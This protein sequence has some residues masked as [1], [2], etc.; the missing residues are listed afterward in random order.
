[1]HGWG[2]VE[3]GH[4]PQDTWHPLLYG[5]FLLGKGVIRVDM[6]YVSSLFVGTKISDSENINK[7]K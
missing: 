4:Q 5:A 6:T 2:E 7:N 3:N 1:V